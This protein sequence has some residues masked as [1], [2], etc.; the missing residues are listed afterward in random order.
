MWAQAETNQTHDTKLTADISVICM[1]LS[2]VVFRWLKLL[3]LFVLT[4]I[5]ANKGTHPLLMSFRQIMKGFD[6]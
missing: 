5:I 2:T 3:A 1:E 6:V 4:N